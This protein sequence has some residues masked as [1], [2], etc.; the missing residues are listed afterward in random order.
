MNT[1]KY[2]EG[3]RYTKLKEMHSNIEAAKTLGVPEYK[4]RQKVKRRGIDKKTL[5]ELYQG[6]YTPKRPG[7]FNIKKIGEINRDL[8]EKEGVDIPNPFYEAIPSIT[9]FINS[10]RR[11]SLEGDNLNLM[12]FDQESEVGLLP[13]FDQQSNINPIVNSQITNAPPVLAASGTNQN[14][15]R[16]VQLRDVFDDTTSIV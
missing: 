2:T 15:T 7:D 14:L 10:N 16:P 6:V 5:S 4:I 3:L 11:I 1:Y 8:N 12:D 9:N 13:S